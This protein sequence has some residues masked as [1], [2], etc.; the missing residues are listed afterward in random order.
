PCCYGRL[1]RV[2]TYKAALSN[3]S[4]FFVAVYVQHRPV[5]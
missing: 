1:E 2:K 4:G 5:S 3:Q